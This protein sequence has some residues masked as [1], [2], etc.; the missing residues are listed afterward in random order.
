MRTSIFPK[1]PSPRWCRQGYEGVSRLTRAYLEVGRW[2]LSPVLSGV[3]AHG[4]LLVLYD[5]DVGVQQR[6]H[7]G[8]ALA[9]LVTLTAYDD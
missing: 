9:V 2:S 1:V 5:R 6:G 8:S 7:V 4:H 3:L